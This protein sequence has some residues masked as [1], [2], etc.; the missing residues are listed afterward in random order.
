MKL[1]GRICGSK[2]ESQSHVK[3]LKLAGMKSV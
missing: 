1:Y 3:L 2:G